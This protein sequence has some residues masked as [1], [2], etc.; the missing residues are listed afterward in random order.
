[1]NDDRRRATLDHSALGGGDGLGMAKSIRKAR[2][3]PGLFF[4]Y[5]WNLMRVVSP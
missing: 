2:T 4:H 3:E 5:S 1:M